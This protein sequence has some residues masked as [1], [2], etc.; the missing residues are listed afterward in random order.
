LQISWNWTAK[1]CANG[2][3]PCAKTK[4]I[5]TVSICDSQKNGTARVRIFAKSLQNEVAAKTNYFYLHANYYF[6]FSDLWAKE[7]K[8][9]RLPCAF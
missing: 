2:E 4:I 5:A 1:F 9:E 8:D 3:R 7:H 6:E